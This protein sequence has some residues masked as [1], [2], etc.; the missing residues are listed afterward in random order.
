WY[1]HALCITHAIAQQDCGQNWTR[2][3][4]S[5][6]VLFVQCS[7]TS[8]T[9]SPC[10]TAT[11]RGVHA[12]LGRCTAARD[13]RDVEL[14][15]LMAR[16]EHL[17]AASAFHG[18]RSAG[19][20]GCPTAF[21]R[22]ANQSLM[23]KA[24]QRPVAHARKSLCKRLI[25]LSLPMLGLLLSTPALAL[26]AALSASKSTSWVQPFTSY[27]FWPSS[28]PAT[29]Q[30]LENGCSPSSHSHEPYSS[31]W[32]PGEQMTTFDAVKGAAPAYTNP[33]LDTAVKAEEVQAE[34]SPQDGVGD[35]DSDPITLQQRV[36]AQTQAPDY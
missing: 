12:V 34:S 21:S 14:G 2:R 18:R 25:L 24:G 33:A 36:L 20:H 11:K 6:R 7:W 13:V 28:D 17:S 31:A 29:S 23:R 35:M 30:A 19:T 9:G 4:H 15:A 22:H 32:R 5:Y 27:T 1:T 26:G 10:S 3:R 16:T 8:G